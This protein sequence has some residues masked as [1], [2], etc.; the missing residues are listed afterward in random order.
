MS[1][2]A[3]S[4]EQVKQVAKDLLDPLLADVRAALTKVTGAQ[5]KAMENEKAFRKEL[6]SAIQRTERQAQ[7]LLAVQKNILKRMADL[8]NQQ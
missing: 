8:E 2:I 7:Q 1:Y 6:K 5:S 3:A 4:P